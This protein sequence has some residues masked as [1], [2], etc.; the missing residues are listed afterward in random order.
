V[1]ATLAHIS[2]GVTATASRAPPRKVN[3]E[4]RPHRDRSGGD[5]RRLQCLGRGDQNLDVAGPAVSCR[6]TARSRST[7]PAP[8]LVV[9]A[10][11]R[12]SRR[13]GS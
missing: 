7:N 12:V 11:T 6:P 4:R 13:L 8:N 9:H 5:R 2:D 1:Q 3:A 10:D